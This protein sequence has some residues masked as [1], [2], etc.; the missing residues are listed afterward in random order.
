MV[1]D[2]EAIYLKPLWKIAKVWM[3]TTMQSGGAS[4]VTF[5]QVLQDG[6]E[7]ELKHGPVTIV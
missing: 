4:S 1:P 5:V 2:D 7:T 3:Q 6:Q